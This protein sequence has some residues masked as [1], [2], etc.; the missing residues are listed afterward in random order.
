MGL[1]E[2]AP[3]VVPAVASTFPSTSSTDGAE[4]NVLRRGSSGPSDREF[5]N[6]CA[7][8]LT[9][10]TRKRNI[11]AKTLSQSKQD[12]IIDRCLMFLVFDL[13]IDRNLAR[14]KSRQ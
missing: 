6:R 3:E 2:R 12:F 7:A 4:R 13:Q 10:R 14:F 8:E 5:H 11:S 9:V 1:L